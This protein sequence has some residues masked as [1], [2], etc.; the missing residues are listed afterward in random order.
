MTEED[1]PFLWDLHVLTMR[2]YVEPIW[3]WDEAQQRRMLRERSRPTERLIIEVADQPAGH[4]ERILQDNVMII[5]NIQV[6]PDFQGRG[7][8]SSVIR[9][10]CRSAE[11]T[12]RLGVLVTNPKAEALYLR[13]G[14]VVTEKTD[15][16]HFM[17]REIL[18]TFVGD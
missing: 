14:F 13:L 10:E 18:S 16:H 11:R 12:V 8:G 4:L 7:L 6:H 3:G 15:T 2:S 1:Y 17:Q 5:G 9:A